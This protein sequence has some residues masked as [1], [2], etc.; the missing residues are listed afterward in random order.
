MGNSNG[1]DMLAR[2]SS[3]HGDRH[4]EHIFYKNL[5]CIGLLIAMK[6]RW[7]FFDSR[8]LPLLKTSRGSR[9]N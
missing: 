5:S 9:K 6:H 7:I 8:P 3:G 4:M 1:L 2:K